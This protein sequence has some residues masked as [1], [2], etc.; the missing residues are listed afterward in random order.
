MYKYHRPDATIDIRFGFRPENVDKR[1]LSTPDARPNYDGYVTVYMTIGY[2][3]YGPYATGIKTFESVWR[4]RQLEKPPLESRQLVK[5]LINYQARIEA[6]HE[7]LL[8]L[9]QPI[10]GE[11]L[12]NTVQKGDP[13]GKVITL[14]Q[15][16]TEFMQARAAMIEPR[17]ELR[18]C[19]QISNATFNSYPKRWEM[20]YGYLVSINRT[21]MPVG[22]I[23]YP[24]ATELKEFLTR[25]Q[26]GGGRRY[27]P[28]TVNKAISFLKQL[29]SYAVSKGYIGFN[30]VRDFACRGGSVAN[31]KPLTKEQLDLLETC[32]LPY[33]W[34]RICDSWLVAA[35]LCLHY[36]DFMKIPKMK[37]IEKDG[38]LFIQHTRS[39]QQGSSLKQTVNVTDRAKRI[40]D[41][42]GGVEGLY[43]RHSGFFSAYLKKIAK[44]VDLRDENGDLIGLQ[45][46]H[47]R[48]TGL[49]QRVIDGANGVQLAKMAGWSKPAYAERY[50]GNP[51]DIVGEFVKSTG[52]GQTGHRPDPNKPFI[53]LKRAS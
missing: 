29:M 36:S 14:M 40:I 5:E 43:Y 11:A 21:K 8:R 28:V 44:K 15:V 23:L 1:P 49:T 37:F 27:M 51:V 42:Y 24:F 12:M 10:D 25:Q 39:K 7:A 53:M 2:N 17:Q 50:I 32:E 34:R 13:S 18:T 19:D 22:A 6:A 45:F 52:S 46:G 35:E 47:G 3:D 4:G 31:P 16:Y 26:K 38:I 9:D 20:I 48:D 41:K 30:P 33:L